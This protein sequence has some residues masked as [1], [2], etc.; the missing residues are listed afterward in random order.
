M[1]IPHKDHIV[2]T[3]IT[4]NIIAIFCEFVKVYGDPFYFEKLQRSFLCRNNNI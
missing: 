1:K 4:K 2:F 3:K